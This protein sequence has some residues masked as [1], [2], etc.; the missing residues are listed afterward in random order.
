MHKYL[1]KPPLFIVDLRPVS[2]PM[3][4]IGDH[5][6]AEQISKISKLFPFSPPKSFTAHWYR[7]LMGPLSIVLA[8]VG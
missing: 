5:N 3:C 2:H 1:G 8:E 7:D 6:V 4:V